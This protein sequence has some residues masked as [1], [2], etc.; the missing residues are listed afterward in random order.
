VLGT[1]QIVCVNQSGSQRR[2]SNL[3]FRTLHTEQQRNIFMSKYCRYI[4]A[5]FCRYDTSS[6]I[7]RALITTSPNPTFIFEARFDPKSQ[8]YRVTQ[9]MRFCNWWHSKVT[10]LNNSELII[11]NRRFNQLDCFNSIWQQK[12]PSMRKLLCADPKNTWP[13]LQ[14]CVDWWRHCDV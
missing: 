5:E 8:I 12:C 1:G 3:G 14:L 6:Y 4:S 13:D 7:G 2:S 9:D 11:F 10:W